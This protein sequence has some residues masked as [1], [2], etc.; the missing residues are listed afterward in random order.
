MA[1]PTRHNKDAGTIWN[2][3]SDITSEEIKN[4]VAK[5][6]VSFFKVISYFTVI[7]PAAVYFADKLQG[8]VSKTREREGDRELS[9]KVTQQFIK[10]HNLK[11]FT[12]ERLV[13]LA[14]EE[15]NFDPLYAKDYGKA[16]TYYQIAAD[17]GNAKAQFKL[18]K[19]YQSGM[20]VGTDPQK[21]FQLYTK[22]ANQEYSPAQF[23]LGLCYE[24]G[25]G[26]VKDLQKAFQL[27]TKAA[28][29]G[30]VRAQ[31]NL[32]ICYLTGKGVG[33]NFEEAVKNLRLAADQGHARSQYNL[34]L[35]YTKGE[36]V[37]I[38]KD[39]AIKLYKLAAAQGHS[40]AKDQLATLGIT[41]YQL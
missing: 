26:V 25:S 20:F 30:N 7:I 16:I 2:Q 32:G 24:S 38:D 19:L 10:S 8:R 11:S 28:N 6:I 39:K 40:H 1:E 21:A 41:N 35:C 9:E 22:A 31:A 15:F 12:T 13:E 29:Q 23:E 5:G 33:L 17:R 36:G 27:Y 18:G 37:V 3:Y 34:A 4:P 14:D